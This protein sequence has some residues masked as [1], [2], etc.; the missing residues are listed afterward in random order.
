MRRKEKNYFIENYELYRKF[1]W[2]KPLRCLS[3]IDAETML[4]E[5]HAGACGEHQ[6]GRKL[7]HSLIENGYYWPTMK[8]DSLKFSKKYVPC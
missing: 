8:E 3:T 6:G 1:F 4:V 5:V 7:Y 2:G